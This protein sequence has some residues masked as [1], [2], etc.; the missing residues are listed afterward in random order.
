MLKILSCYRTLSNKLTAWRSSL[1][2]HWLHP[3]ITGIIIIDFQGAG[4]FFFLHV[5]NVLEASW[6]VMAHTQQADF[7][8]R[9]NGRGHLNRR[10]RQ[11]SRLLAAEVCGSAVVMFDT[12]CSEAV[13]RVLAIHFIRQFPFHFPSRA[14]PRAITFQLESITRCSQHSNSW[15]K[16]MICIIEKLT[17]YAKSKVSAMA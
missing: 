4:F 2:K 10:G 16:A 8:F 7:V 17:V 9:R 12:P 5:Q 6:N 1:L 14:S 13:W 15:S 3:W 11:F